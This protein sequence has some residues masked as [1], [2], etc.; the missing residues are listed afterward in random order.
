MSD[1]TENKLI[2]AILLLFILIGFSYALV[3]PAFEASDELWHYP[4]VRHLADGNPLPVQVYDP[5]LAGPWKQEAS[6][7]PLY[8]YVAA[9][10]TFWVDTADMETVRW[11][12]PHVDNGVITADGNINLAIHPDSFSS[13]EGTLLAIRIIRLFSVLLGAWT[14]LLTYLIAKEVVPDRPYIAL[15]AAAVDGFTPM[16]VFISGAVNNDNLAIPLA[17]LGML[18]LIRMV[19]RPDTR[20]L[21]QSALLVGA[22]IGAAVLTKQGTI[23]LIPL[24][25]GAYFI[26]IWQQNNETLKTAADGLRAIGMGIGRALIMMG[27]MFVPIVLK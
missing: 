1:G 5:A 14:V 11:L 13:W 20:P 3:T 9:G 4:M 19:T 10:L 23:G 27:I 18:L 21:W 17:S 15:A 12:N 16:F 6:Q 24:S 22:V 8:Y 7:P 2:R 25:F 26:A